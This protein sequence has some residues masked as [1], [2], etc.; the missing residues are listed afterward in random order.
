M[1]EAKNPEKRLFPQELSLCSVTN[2]LSPQDFKTLGSEHSNPKKNK[3]GVKFLT[4][5][6]KGGTILNPSQQVSST[7]NSFKQT[8][9]TKC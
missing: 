2:K 8:Q 6:N 7:L 9:L 3:G 4:Q 5:K 1:C